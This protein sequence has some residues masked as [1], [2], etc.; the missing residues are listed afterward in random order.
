MCALFTYAPSF[1]LEKQSSRFHERRISLL[2]EREKP[3]L[4]HH[5]YYNR[6]YVV[7]VVV[8]DSLSRLVSLYQSLGLNYVGPLRKLF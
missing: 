1:F 2:L 4:Y 5:D 6:L 7:L 8:V 3:S